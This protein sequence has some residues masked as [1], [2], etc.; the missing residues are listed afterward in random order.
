MFYGIPADSLESIPSI[1]QI[2]RQIQKQELLKLMP[3]EWLF[4]YKKFQQNSQPVQTADAC[5]EKRA[6][7]TIKL[8]FQSPTDQ[9]LS[10]V[11]HPP[12]SQS[13][14]RNS[15]SYSSMITA[16][17]TAQEDLP[18]HGFASDDYPIYPDKVNGHFLWDV[19][20]S[21]MCDPDCPCL[22]DE[23]DDNDFNRRPRRCKKK[24]HKLNSCYQKPPLPPD[25][26]D[27]LTL[28]PIYRKGLR[29][30]QK[31]YEQKSCRQEANQPML[32][33]IPI[34]SCIMFSSSSYQEHFPPLEKQT[35]P[36][37]KVTTKPFVHSPVTPNG[38]IEEP[39]P[40]EVVL[41]WQTQTARAQNSAFR[42][43]DEKIERVACQVK[44][45]NTKVD[46]ITSQLEQMYLDMQN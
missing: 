3:L 39:K 34:Q 22:E 27:S 8:I 38:Q 31:E 35:D 42:S 7:N 19:P 33:S 32:H 2:P 1:V 26:P 6:N 4:N 40:F 10:I 41:N 24:N 17:S 9:A 45:T 36:Q 5:F 14:L 46:K 21:Y 18:I 37:T 25:D 20:G 15:F 16:V 44:Q 23:E 12:S 13:S 43:L 29:L 28:L 11:S 30:I